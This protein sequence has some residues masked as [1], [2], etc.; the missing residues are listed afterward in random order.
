MVY[1]WVGKNQFKEVIRLRHFTSFSVSNS[2][3]H[4]VFE[5]QN[6]RDPFETTKL[7]V[8]LHN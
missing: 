5:A 1:K 2:Y 6:Q 3:R 8:I 7:L 4:H